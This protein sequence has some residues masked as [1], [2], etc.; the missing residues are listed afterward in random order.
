MK[1]NSL[2][3]GNISKSILFFLI[4]I[5]VSSLI[6]QLYSVVDLVLIGKFIGAEATAAVGASSLI[7]TCLIGF[8]N[9]IAVGTN[10]VTAHIFG[11]SD[12]SSLK[13]IMQTVWTAGAIGGLLLMVVGL[14]LSPHF[15]KWMNTPHSILDTG[16]I[17]LRIY[18]LSLPAIVLYNLCSGILRAMGD[19]KSPMFF[20]VIGGLLNVVGCILMVAVWR[21]GVA[22]AATATF[23]SQTVAAL[24]ILGHLHSKKQS[25]RLEFKVK[26]FNPI[27]LKRILAIGIPSGVQ[28]M[29]ITFSIIILQSQINKFG[30]HVMAA[31][32][33]YYKIEMLIYLP[34]LA[35]GQALVSF[36]GQNHGAEQYE[37]I[38]KGTSLSIRWGILMTACISALLL[39]QGPLVMRLFTDHQQVIFYGCQIMKVTFPFYF[40]YVIIECSSSEIR[41]RGEATIPMVITLFSFCVVRL[42]ALVVL[43]SQWHDIRGIAAVYPFSWAV[44]AG[45]M[46]FARLQMEKKEH[47]L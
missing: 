6:Q 38:K 18:L 7:I 41:G 36:V 29:I 12:R 31:F 21:K 16:V 33:A 10:V 11:S 3:E 20:Q 34:I 40:L 45:L 28:A 26:G 13:E 2:T 8:F 1:T 42:T 23:I 47:K 15:L 9:G 32:A 39:L 30:V 43:I 17:Y 22:G 24:L 35:L 19:S 44:A 25:V 46:T 37:R 5:L 4:P 27:L 14:T